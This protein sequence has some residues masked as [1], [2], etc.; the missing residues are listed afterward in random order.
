MSIVKEQVRLALFISGFTV[1]GI[2]FHD[3]PFPIIGMPAVGML[4]PAINLFLW[5][6]LFLNN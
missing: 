5:I 2:A 6:K 1:Y 3:H 4:T